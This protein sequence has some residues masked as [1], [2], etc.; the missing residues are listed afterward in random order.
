M[1]NLLRLVCSKNVFKGCVCYILLRLK[2]N[3]SETRE[4]AFYFTPK[5]LFHFQ[6]KQILEF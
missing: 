3:T 1:L 6:E 2:E 5:A 4:N